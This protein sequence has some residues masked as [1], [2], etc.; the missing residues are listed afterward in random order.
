MSHWAEIDE[1]NVVVRVLVGDDTNGEEYA[2][3]FIVKNL[4]GTWIQ[5]SYNGTIRGIFA[6][7]GDIY[8]PIK[9]EFIS[10]IEYPAPNQ[11]I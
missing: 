4:G 1:N 10:P 11:M 6:G 7:I 9:D 3:K 8:D 2:G 5:T